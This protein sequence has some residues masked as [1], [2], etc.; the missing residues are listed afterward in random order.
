LIRENVADE[1]MKLKQQPGRN[2]N[3]SGSG[4]LVSWLLRQGLLDRL[5]LL[6][7]PVV[8][9]R[10][11]RLFEGEGPQ[12]PLKLTGSRTFSNGVVHLTYEPAA[13]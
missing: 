4:T 12:V 11:K 7:F 2:I 1:V 8:A 5:D 10:G 9:G 3:M 13:D 6:V